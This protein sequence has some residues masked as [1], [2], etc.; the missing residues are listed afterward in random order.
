V[1]VYFDG[2]DNRF[3][4]VFDLMDQSPPTQHISLNGETRAASG[5]H[6]KKGTHHEIGT[7]S[8]RESDIDPGTASERLLRSD[9]MFPAGKRPPVMTFNSKN[10]CRSLAGKI[11]TNNQ[12]SEPD[13]NFLWLMD[14]GVSSY[15]SWLR[16]EQNKLKKSILRLESFIA[17]HGLEPHQVTATTSRA[18]QLSESNVERIDVGSHEADELPRTSENDVVTMECAREYSK[19]YSEQLLEFI[20][21]AINW[22]QQR[23]DFATMLDDINT[24]TIGRI[25]IW[26]K[27]T[28]YA[29]WGPD[30]EREVVTV[31]GEGLVYVIENGL[32]EGPL[33]A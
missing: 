12:R 26:T 7:V 33:L 32:E 20:Y 22:T 18:I 14:F 3:E 5:R 2:I 21:T 9:S 25:E 29:S 24:C 13:V 6:D 8:D 4:Q 30:A 31:L 19:W 11:S 10:P 15:E 27:S 17:N 23:Y 28:K 16:R 1:E